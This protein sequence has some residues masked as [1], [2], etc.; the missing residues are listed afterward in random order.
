MVEEMVKTAKRT[1]DGARR[2][3]HDPPGPLSTFK[4][5]GGVNDSEPATLHERASYFKEA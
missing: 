1:L 4:R 3:M 2:L 5:R